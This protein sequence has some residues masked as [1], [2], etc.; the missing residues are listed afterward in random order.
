[1]KYTVDHDLHIHT[2]LSSC[3]RHPEQTPELH[4]LM[5][6]MIRFIAQKSKD[7]CAAK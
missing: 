3:S 5:M 4:G 6:E 2:R 7:A 1:M